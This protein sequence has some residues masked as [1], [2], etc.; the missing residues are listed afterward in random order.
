MATGPTGACH[1]AV[2]VTVWPSSM[3][4]FVNGFVADRVGDKRLIRIGLATIIAGVVM[5]MIP[6]GAD[7][8]ALCG[9]VVVGIGCAPVYPSVIHATPSNFG[10]ENSQAI[11]GIQMASAYVGTT[12]MPP[13]FGLIANYA[14][15]GFYPVFLLITAAVMFVMTELLNYTMKSKENRK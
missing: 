10:R 5:I 7:I 13:A 9:L 11:V 15:R 3:R 14:D 12:L 8:P 2:N 1:A 6:V 4:R